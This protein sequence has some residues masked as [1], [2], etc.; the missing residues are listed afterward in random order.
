MGCTSLFTLAF[1]NKGHKSCRSVRENSTSINHCWVNS[2]LKLETHYE[3]KNC[4]NSFQLTFNMKSFRIP[5]VHSINSIEKRKDKFD[6]KDKY[7]FLRT[8]NV[9]LKFRQILKNVPNKS[10]FESIA[11]SLKRMIIKII[12]I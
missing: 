10:C 12:L 11:L 6:K 1:I 8:E 3:L 9:V 4:K 7:W 2:S 5:K